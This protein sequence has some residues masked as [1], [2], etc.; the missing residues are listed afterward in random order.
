MSTNIKKRCR[1]M[2]QIIEHKIPEMNNKAITEIVGD[3]HQKDFEM[4][5]ETIAVMRAQY[6]KKVV[7]LARLDKSDLDV[8]TYTEVRHLKLA[9]QESI[10]SF[11]Q[12]KH[13]LERGHFKLSE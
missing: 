2:M 8:K 10:E 13:A 12:L 11:N 9:F 7:E 6:L 3:V 1:R 4:L 5:A